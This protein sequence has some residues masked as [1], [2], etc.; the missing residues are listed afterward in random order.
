MIVLVVVAPF[1]DLRDD[2]RIDIG[3]GDGFARYL[4]TEVADQ[5]LDEGG[6]L[7]DFAV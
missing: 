2:E 6:S 7:S 5:V 4:L 3:N 1:D